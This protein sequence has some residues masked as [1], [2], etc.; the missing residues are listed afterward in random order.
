MAVLNLDAN[1]QQAIPF[2]RPRGT[3]LSMQNLNAVTDIYWSYDEQQLNQTAP[4][5]TPIGIKLAKAGG[6]TQIYPFPGLIWFRQD[7]SGAAQ[8]LLECER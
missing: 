8:V 2:R 3:C 4:N 6:F 7:S 1:N 5:G